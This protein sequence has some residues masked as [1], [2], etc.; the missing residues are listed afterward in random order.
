MSDT[1]DGDKKP[2]PIFNPDD[3]V[4]PTDPT[5]ADAPVEEPPVEEP[6]VE[7][8]EKR[9]KPAR[10][11]KTQKKPDAAPAE[12]DTPA[13]ATGE[14]APVSTGS[15]A[16]GEFA[17]R[18]VVY[19]QAPVPPRLRGNRGVGSLL[20]VLGAVV[21]AAIFAIAS[22]V[23]FVLKGDAEPMTTFSLFLQNAVFWVPVLVFLVAF[24]LLVLVVNRAGW[25]AHVFGS[26]VVG[27]AVYFG[28]IGILL[29]IGNIGAAA[30][31]DAPGT[32]GALALN[33]FV[34]IAALVAREVSIWV[35]LAI[36]ARGRRVKARNV[37]L[38]DE[39]EQEHAETKARY[40][41]AGTTA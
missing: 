26:L 4:E 8:S 21:F 1:A 22:I 39:W 41:Q 13:T 35:G 5:P 30:T 3:V 40:E 32:F 33:P 34:I 36:A 31:G 28:S 9:E 27:L 37:E 24:V 2:K 17:G 7:K 25:A 16:E 12:T 11:P 38:V 6:A 10:A 20:A 14:V 29:L 19:V 15:T 18:E 23:A